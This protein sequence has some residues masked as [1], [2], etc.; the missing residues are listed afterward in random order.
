MLTP[1][2]RQQRDILACA[3]T[4][5]GKTF[6]F[7]LPLLSLYPPT[8]SLDQTP[9]P[10]VIIIEPTRELAMQVLREANRLANDGGW[11]VRVLGEEHRK[12]KV[13]LGVVK[14]KHQP[15]S[16]GK[17]K[18]AG[19]D[20]PTKVA[21]VPEVPLEG[22]TGELFSSPRKWFQFSQLILNGSDILIS[23]P[24]GLVFAIQSGRVDATKFVPVPPPSPA[25]SADQQLR[26]SPSQPAFKP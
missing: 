18:E 26:P 15:R 2:P 20:G 22:P 4:G 19:Q 17:G 9:K 24:L 11:K 12:N 13:E 1:R 21:V 14:P 6:A 8:A 16:K 25:P 5:S 7:L 10:T 23:T 3:P